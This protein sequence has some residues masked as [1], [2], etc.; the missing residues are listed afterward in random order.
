MSVAN[1]RVQDCCRVVGVGEAANDC[2]HLCRRDLSV[3]DVRAAFGR[4]PRARLQFLTTSIQ[5]CSAFLPHFI[6]CGS[7]AVDARECCREEGMPTSCLPLCSGAS[8]S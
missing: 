7:E 5:R 2:L 6:H 4:I 1:A 8:Y 3:T